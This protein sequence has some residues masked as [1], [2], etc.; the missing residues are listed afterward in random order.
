MVDVTIKSS[1]FP[2]RRYPHLNIWDEAVIDVDIPEK[3]A[4]KSA[5]QARNE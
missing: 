4:A 2:E 3:T 1:F 5:E